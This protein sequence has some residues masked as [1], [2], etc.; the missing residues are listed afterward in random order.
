M[1]L[2]TQGCKVLYKVN[3]IAGNYSNKWYDTQ[4]E[5]ILHKD[6]SFVFFIKEGLL[7]DTIKGKW[8]IEGKQLSLEANNKKSFYKA[9]KCDTC[10]NI[11]LEVYDSR[12]KE[13][14]IA[15]YK[16]YVKDVVKYE[17]DTDLPIELPQSIDSIQ[18]EALGYSSLSFDV[19]KNRKKIE[20]F[21]SKPESNLLENKFY[22]KGNKIKLTN[23]LILKKQ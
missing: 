21:L 14:L 16:A 10:N 12:N 20:V 5:L 1:L 22:V 7:T 6:N 4:H 2:I 18:V 9:N 23:G 17:G 13:K 15:F 19:D 8:N 3:D 11:Y